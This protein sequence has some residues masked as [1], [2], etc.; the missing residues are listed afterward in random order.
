MRTQYVVAL[1]LSK[2]ETAFGMMQTGWGQFLVSSRFMRAL[3]G[4]AKTVIF[5]YLALVAAAETAWAGTPQ[6]VWL[7]TLSTICLALTVLV[8]GLTV[9]RGFPVLVEARRFFGRGG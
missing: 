8:V 3:Y 2:G 7:P 5:V 4:I 1:V 6:A 9:L